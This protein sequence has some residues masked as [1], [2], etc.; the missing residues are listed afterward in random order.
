MEIVDEEVI[1]YELIEDLLTLL[2]LEP[3]NNNT[4]LLAPCG[5]E[6]DPWK[7]I[8]SWCFYLGN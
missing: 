7:A 1:N 3:E 2:M 8:Q 4:M 5:N 6:D